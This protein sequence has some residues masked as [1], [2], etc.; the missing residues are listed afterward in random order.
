MHVCP[1]LPTSTNICLLLLQI[2][3]HTVSKIQTK[4]GPLPVQHFDKIRH[5]CPIFVKT[6]FK[7]PISNLFFFFPKLLSMTAIFLC[8]FRFNIY[9]LPI[10]HAILSNPITYLQRLCAS[11]LNYSKCITYPLDYQYFF[12]INVF[13][14]ILGVSLG[15]NLGAW[16]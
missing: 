8:I 11:S 10:S 15:V 13:F 4:N 3:Q 7:N 6:F 2:A 9:N 16:V 12:C 5:Q 14:S 1:P